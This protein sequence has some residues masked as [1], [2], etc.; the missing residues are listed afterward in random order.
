MRKIDNKNSERK[1]KKTQENPRFQWPARCF[2]N[3]IKRKKILCQT[4]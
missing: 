2:D 1:N 4:T 3:K